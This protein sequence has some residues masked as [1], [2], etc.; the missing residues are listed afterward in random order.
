MCDRSFFEDDAPPPR[1]ASKPDEP[2]KPSREK[3]SEQARDHPEATPDFSAVI[4]FGC[5]RF[6]LPHRM[7]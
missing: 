2:K 7:R 6:T 4:P 5:H 1:T 3:V